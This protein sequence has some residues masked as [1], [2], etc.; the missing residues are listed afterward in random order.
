MVTNPEYA[1][2][3]HWVDIGRGCGVDPYDDA[4][5]EGTR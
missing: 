4:R 5:M 1:A 3:R 2:S